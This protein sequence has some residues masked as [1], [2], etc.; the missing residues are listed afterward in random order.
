MSNNRSSSG[1]RNL[2]AM[3][4]N[5]DSDAPPDRG[6]S[7]A[8]SEGVASNG[9]NTPRRLSSVRRSFVAVERSGQQGSQIGLKKPGEAV[10]VADLRRDSVSTNETKSPLAMAELKEAIGEELSLR[11]QTSGA[12]TV[13]EVA[14]DFREDGGPSPKAKIAESGITEQIRPTKPAEPSTPNVTSNAP[15]TPKKTKLDK[16]ISSEPKVEQSDTGIKSPSSAGQKQPK[17]IPAAANVQPRTPSKS[18]TA[19]QPLSFEQQTLNNARDPPKAPVIQELASS[20]R[21]LEPSID[22][23][24]TSK[25]KPI[26]S[27][28]SKT[29]PRKTTSDDNGA[30]AKSTIKPKASSASLRNLPDEKR[31]KSA[32][33]TVS[34]PASSSQVPAS[35]STSKQPKT[36]VDA[37]SSSPSKQPKISI[38]SV[39]SPSKAALSRREPISQAPPATAVSSTKKPAKDP[40]DSKAEAPAAKAP[41]SVTDTTSSSPSKSSFTSPFKKPRPR[42]PTRPVKLPASATAQ[43][44]SSA[45]KTLTNGGSMPG[46]LARSNTTATIRRQSSNL[47]RPRLAA[48]TA[49][50]LKKQSS[51]HSLA[52]PPPP[53]QIK[54]RHSNA[55]LKAPDQS[56]LARMMRPT[57]SSASKTHEKAEAKATSQTKGI[58]AQRRSAGSTA[59]SRPSYAP[60]EAD[61]GL[62][63]VEDTNGTAPNAVGP[64]PPVIAPETVA[65]EPEASSPNTKD[66]QAS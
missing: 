4:E 19:S 66:L 29:S 24:A 31:K 1:V 42:S 53:A 45:A 22:E 38:D 14:A 8:G 62:N 5:K 30:K 20:D 3:F 26:D 25:T 33:L 28:P 41:P 56:F 65:H 23:A 58:R 48:P 34:K 43:T 61:D 52:G 49:S 64:E 59:S 13:P 21:G 10:T 60:S 44:E 16:V 37:V 17:S 39:T 50:S 9:T 54:P 18:K 2:R 27:N 11:E 57:A 63:L 6:R 55:N 36:P 12:G 51:R 15:A 7:P 32:G 47:G 35:K 46:H 40:G